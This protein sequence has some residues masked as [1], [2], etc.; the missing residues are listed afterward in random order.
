MTPLYKVLVGKFIFAIYH[1]PRTSK[2]S[3]R[4]YDFQSMLYIIISVPISL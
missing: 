1:E 4:L 2:L 3:Y